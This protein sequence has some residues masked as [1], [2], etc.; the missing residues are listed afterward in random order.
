VGKVLSIACVIRGGG[1]GE[2]VGVGGGDNSYDCLQIELLLNEMVRQCVEE[3]GVRGRV[4]IAHVVLRFDEAAV[5]KVFP[6][7][8]GEGFGE[9]RVV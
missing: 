2:L 6:I 3:F 9:E 4:G 8:V 7:A 5:E 1:G